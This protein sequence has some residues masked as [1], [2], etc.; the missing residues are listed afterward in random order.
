MRISVPKVSIVLFVCVHLAIMI[1][2]NYSMPE[3]EITNINNPS[4]ASHHKSASEINTL[5]T[6]FEDSQIGHRI[7]YGIMAT[8]LLLIYTICDIMIYFHLVT[9]QQPRPD[10]DILAIYMQPDYNGWTYRMIAV[11]LFMDVVSQLLG[12]M[13]V[14]YDIIISDLQAATF[15]TTWNI[16]TYAV[17]RTLT[18]IPLFIVALSILQHLQNIK[19][20]PPIRKADSWTI[21]MYN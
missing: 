15:F 11:Y 16:C 2:T 9:M 10:Q 3:K 7:I 20:I 19:S 12:V 1:G 18:T 17:G 21:Y 14:Y 6:V 13:C 4:S 5:R 8:S